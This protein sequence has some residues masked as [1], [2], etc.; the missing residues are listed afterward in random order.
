ME[1]EHIM[2]TVAAQGCSL[3]EITGGEPLVQQQTPELIRRLM[4]KGFTVLVETN[5]SMPIAGLPEGCI[6]IIDIKCPGSNESQS[7][8]WDL[9]DD[10]A[11]NDEIKFVIGSRTDYDYACDIIRHRLPDAVRGDKIHL[12]PV[13]GKVDPRQLAEWLMSDRLNARLSLQLHKLIWD[14]DQRGV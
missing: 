11:M 14:P 5:G 3:V 6:R 2:D 9:L 8:L 4:E 13:F 7:F 10:L 1:L 12:S